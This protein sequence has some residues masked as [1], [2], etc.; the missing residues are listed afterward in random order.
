MFRKILVAVGGEQDAA[1][2]IPVVKALAGAFDS[3]VLVIHM[4]E[5]TVTSVATIEQETIPE[6]FRFGQ[7]VARALVGAGLRATADI[8]SHRPDHLV[9]FILEKAGKLGADL[10]VIGSHHPHNLRERITGDVG[11]KLAH[12]AA[13]P[14]LL[15]PSGPE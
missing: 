2:S 1:E 14:L 13:C 5:R 15:M 11:R 7:S 10:I 6:S 3:D 12:A 9:D 4:R 8:D